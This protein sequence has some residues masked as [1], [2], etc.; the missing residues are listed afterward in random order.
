MV[1]SVVSLVTRDDAEKFIN[2]LK[3]EILNYYKTYPFSDFLASPQEAVEQVFPA[4]AP[5]SRE[6]PRH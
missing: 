5:N 3:G 1:T 2:I 6:I 4:H